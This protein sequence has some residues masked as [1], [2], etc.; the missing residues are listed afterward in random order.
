[1]SPTPVLATGRFLAF[2]AL[3]ANLGDAPITLRQAAQGI[4][5]LTDTVRLAGSSVSTRLS[6]ATR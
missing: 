4:G 1:M 3:G 5:A 6:S 2:I